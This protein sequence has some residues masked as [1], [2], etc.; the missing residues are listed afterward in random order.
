MNLLNSTSVSNNPSMD[1]INNLFKNPSVFIILAVVVVVYII[2]FLSLGKNGSNGGISN[3]YDSNNINN[4]STGNDDDSSSTKIITII[5][6]IVII[7]VLLFNILQYFFGI[8]LITSIEKLFSGE[9]QI[10]IT[11]ERQQSNNQPI[12][13]EITTE[14]QVFNIPGNEYGYEDAKLLCSAYG[15]RLAN[16]NEIENAY[17]K[18]AEWCNYGWSE[19]Q[20]ALF[21]TQKSTFKKLQKVKD[22]EH[23]CGRSGINGGYIANPN[24]KFGVN[25]Y[26]YKPDMT[27]EEEELMETN[28]PYPKTEKDIAMENRVEF[29]KTKIDDIIVSPFNK[30]SWSK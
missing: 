28:S 20:L 8:N 26:G 7:V 18:G 5:V 3:N 25:C 4:Q 22:H 10:D 21:P 12:I 27:Q 19:D 6:I 9:P 2:I 23:D 16:Y 29:W 14:K 30:N 1:Y 15:S 13:P 24:V 17:G 11:I